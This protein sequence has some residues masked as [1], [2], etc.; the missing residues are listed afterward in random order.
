MS[1]GCWCCPRG[2]DDNVT[3]EVQPLARRGEVDCG[4]RRHSK[5]VMTAQA[6]AMTRF[7]NVFGAGPPGQ[8]LELH[9][10]RSGAGISEFNGNQTGF[11]WL[12]CTPE[13][14]T[15]LQ[16]RSG[17]G[18]LASVESAGGVRPGYL[19]PQQHFLAKFDG[20]TLAKIQR[21]HYAVEQLAIQ[22]RNRDFTAVASGFTWCSAAMSRGTT[23]NSRPPQ[24]A[25]NGVG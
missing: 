17:V 8:T 24:A 19:Q 12:R 10:P 20:P 5:P 7:V 23:D 1:L 15:R 3:G 6:N 11:R 22:A 21:L 14:A 18:W 13:L 2:N 16:R 4:G 25:S 9:G